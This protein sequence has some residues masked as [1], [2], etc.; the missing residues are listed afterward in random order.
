VD[1]L[2]N[3]V[4]Q[5][6]KDL[7]VRFPVLNEEAGRAWS[8]ALLKWMQPEQLPRL[9]SLQARHSNEL[10]AL[11]QGYLADPSSGGGVKDRRFSGSEWQRL[12]YFRLLRDLHLL[13]ER[14]W[15][16]TVGMLDLDAATGRRIRFAIRQALDAVSP[17]NFLGTNP[18]AIALARQTG[19]ASLESGLKHL[20]E[21]V[22][23]GRIS[24]SDETAY[25][26][27]RNLAITP[28]A[29]VYEN[30]AMQ[31]I[32]YSASTSRTDERPLFIVPPFINKYYILDLQEEN[33]FVRF[34]VEQ[35]L[36]VF[37]VSWRNVAEEEEGHLSWDD[38]LQSGV[39]T[40]LEV[41]REITGVSGVN[42]LG[43][44]VGG[45]LL[46]CALS[47]SG[48]AVLK[49]VKSLTLL[50]SMLD[51]SDTGD[52]GIF[53]DEAFVRQAEQD[54]RSGGIMAGKK[55]A[56]TFSVLRANDLIWHFVVN[57]YLKGQKP[58]A[59][60][61]LYWNA[62]STNVPGPLYAYYLR[63]M[64][65]E[66]RVRLP[67]TLTMLGKKV[68]LRKLDCPV[69]A[70]AAREDHIVPWRTAYRSVRLLGGSPTFVLAQSGHVAGIISPPVGN[71]RG[72]AKGGP[73]MDNPDAWLDGAAHVSGSWWIH[74]MNWL[75]QHAGRQ[76]I[77]PRSLGSKVHPVVETA[78][79]RYVQIR[80]N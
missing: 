75:K 66:N 12:P 41:V 79:G 72:Y 67:G 37:M 24:M 25:T 26:V 74:W 31:L 48:A 65:L 32:Q 27:G 9:T 42:V 4:S 19:S 55:L 54:F 1:D 5:S 51:F 64:Y 8:A 20:A 6:L 76:R 21:D 28:G 10:S 15:M 69:F 80:I 68:D 44:C 7:V 49:R 14:Q 40:P 36:T 57:N 30:E 13:R 39:L 43:F 11:W 22:A 33:S 3:A 35:G 34:C 70:V 46:S 59:F 38:Y 71:R 73:L 50:A 17:A 18:E 60:D 78:P 77:A 58:P 52:I 47:V 63:N 2:N 61:L 53:V 45:T 23:R 62:D 29:V 16:D 56:D